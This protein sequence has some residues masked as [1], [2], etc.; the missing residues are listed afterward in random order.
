MENRI[1]DL[2]L[3]LKKKKD[4]THTTKYQQYLDAEHGKAEEG[5]ATESPKATKITKPKAAKATKLADDKAPKLTSTQP[6]K[7]KPTLTQPSK[8]VPE[9]KQKLNKSPV[10]QFIIQRR[11]LMPTEASGHAE[12]P[13]LNAK[14]ALTDNETES[15][16]VVSKINTRDQD[17]GQGGPNLGNH[18]E[19]QAGPNL[20][21][22]D[23]GQARSN[24]GDAIESQPQS[25]HVPIH[26][27]T[28]SVPP[29]TT[30]VIDL[31][32]SHLAINNN[33]INNHS[34]YISSTTTTTSTADLI[35][36]KRICELEQY[37]ADLRQYNL[38]L[39]ERLDK[40]R[41][42]LYKLESLSI[43][44][45]PPPPPPPAGAS[46]APGTS[47]ASGSSQ[48]PLPPP[49]STG[50]SGFAQQQGSKALSSSKSAATSAQTM[51]WT[52]SDTR[53]ESAGVSETQELSPTD[54]LIQD[55]SIPNEQYCRQVNKTELTQADLK[56]QAYEV[57]KAFYPDVI[58]IQFQMEECHKM[59]TDQVDWTNP[60]GDQV[61]VDVNQP[62]LFGGPSGSSPTLSISKIKA[63][64]YPNFGLELLVQEQ[65]SSTDMILYHVEKKSDHTCGFL[66]SSDVKPTQD[67]GYE[68]KHD[69]TIIESP[70]AVVFSV[71]NNKRKIMW[72]NEIYKFSDDTLTWILEAMAYR[73][74]EFKIKRLN[75]GSP[76]SMC[77]TILNI[78]S[79]DVGSVSK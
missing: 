64:S 35:L 71:N 29:M 59:L 21:V 27:D 22:Q 36:V 60:E 51:A 78:D 26:Q 23:K 33:N 69:Y 70:R 72:F 47:G 58:H 18:D 38:A 68:F 40:H 53:Y 76:P 62:L 56:G 28:S 50:T 43:P 32:T 13:S 66:V 42:W 41:S 10:D 7:P 39:E 52:T 2:E 16:N 11:T 49:P 57:V 61:R 17:E 12:S 79:L 9:E 5:G 44:H 1:E 74:K 19:G 24:P 67:T 25:S 55:D 14:L 45:Q 4:K 48:F 65:I 46:A 30:S 31:T 37:I 15:D 20:G 75:L 54:S 73:V 34:N 77:Q 3:C 63:A 6:P 8:V